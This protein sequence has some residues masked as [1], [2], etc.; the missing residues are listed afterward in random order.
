M[1]RALESL[2]NS[3]EPRSCDYV[4]NSSQECGSPSLPLS[5]PCPSSLPPSFFLPSLLLLSLFSFLCFSF[6]T[7][8]FFLFVETGEDFISYFNL[9]F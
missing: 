5:L 4:W 8:F 6:Y 7:S 2:E 3:Q 9:S 1:K